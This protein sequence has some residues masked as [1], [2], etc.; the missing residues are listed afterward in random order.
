[1]CRPDA[2]PSFCIEIVKPGHEWGYVP[3]P[4]EQVASV[5]RLVH[6]VKDRHAITRGNVVCHSDIAPRRKQDPGEL[7]PWEELARRRLALP[8]PTRQLTDPLWTDEIGRA[9]C[10]ERVCHYV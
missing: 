4:A 2:R 9:S 6:L 8:R 7:F 5:V 10:R 1:M 3:F